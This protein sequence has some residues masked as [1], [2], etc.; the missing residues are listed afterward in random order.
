MEFVPELV[1]GLE[2]VVA[3][4]C[5]SW[6]MDGRS[7]IVSRRQHVSTRCV[8]LCLC[9]HTHMQVMCSSSCP[10]SIRRKDQASVLRGSH[11]DCMTGD[12]LYPAFCLLTRLSLTGGKFPPSLLD[13]T[14]Q[15]ESNPPPHSC[16]LNSSPEEACDSVTTP[17]NRADQIRRDVSED[18]IDRKTIAL[19]HSSNNCSCCSTSAPLVTGFRKRK[20]K[21]PISWPET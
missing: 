9:T 2:D 4:P 15:R 7:D 19:T 16:G 11:A 17:D 21:I 20:N 13:S 10:P 6:T 8:C 18:S 12:T 1:S 3:D 5:V 14:A